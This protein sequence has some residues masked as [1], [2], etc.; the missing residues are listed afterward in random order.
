MDRLRPAGLGFLA[1]LTIT[2]SSC[3]SATDS[4]PE[5]IKIKER[6]LLENMRRIQSSVETFAADHESDKYPVSVEQFKSYL[7]GGVEGQKPSTVGQVNPFSSVNE[8]PVDFKVQ[9]DLKS[10]RSGKRI[11]IVRGQ[12][13]YCPLQ[14][15]NGYAT[16]YFILAGTHDGK[17]L[18]D[19]K[20]PG[21]VLVLSNLEEED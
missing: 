15:K 17:A 21:K 9:Q 10:L 11:D 4:D 1:V 14:V 3:T 16:A 13:L 2:L 7:P 20:N 6:L 5:S 12:I 18:M 8:F 19:D